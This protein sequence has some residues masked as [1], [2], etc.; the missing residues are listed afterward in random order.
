MNYLMFLVRQTLGVTF[1]TAFPFALLLLGLCSIDILF[2]YP[3]L[4]THGTIPP[5]QM[6]SNRKSRGNFFI[7]KYFIL[8]PSI[9]IDHQKELNK[10][11]KK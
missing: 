8:E 11:Q 3:I 6:I 7:L 5:S 1:M 10:G 2:Y 9:V 4:I